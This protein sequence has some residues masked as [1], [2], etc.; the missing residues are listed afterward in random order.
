MRL[1]AKQIAAYTGGTFACLL[2]TSGP[3][4][5]PGDPRPLRHL[6]HP[7]IHS[8]EPRPH[9]RG[10]P[11]R[12]PARAMP[13]SIAH[14]LVMHMA[15]RVDNALARALG[16]AS[17]SHARRMLPRS[18]QEPVACAVRSPAPGAAT[19]CVCDRNHLRSG[20]GLLR[21]SCSDAYSVGQSVARLAQIRV[22]EI[23][24]YGTIA[25]V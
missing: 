22:D 2:Y 6:H 3:A 1:N 14:L 18:V 7:G 19:C 24:V 16:A 8:R 20:S 11:E 15:L 23:R 21:A 17:P 5:Y 4:R 10:V 12:P 13:A 9:P 25:G